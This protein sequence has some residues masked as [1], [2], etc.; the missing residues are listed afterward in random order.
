MLASPCMS[1]YQF[2]TFLKPSTLTLLR[3]DSYYQMKNNGSHM[4]P[5]V[6]KSVMYYKMVN[7]M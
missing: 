3:P 6:V 2:I 7:I 1:M 5:K 4:W